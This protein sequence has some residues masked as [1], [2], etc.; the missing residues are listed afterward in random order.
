MLLKCPE[1]NT[2][3]SDAATACPKCGHPMLSTTPA[4]LPDASHSAGWL[5]LAA[6]VFSSFTPAILAP[7]FVLVGLIF[8]GKELKG[9]GK[10]FGTLVL[11]LSLLQG[12]FVL[13]HFGHISGTL[14]LTTAGDAD[15]LAASKYRNASLGLPADW[16]EMVKAKCSEEWPADY[17]M[18]NYC[19]HQQ[20][21]AAQQLSEGAPSDVGAGAFQVIRGKCAGEWPRDFQMRAH[22]ER[23][24]FEGVRSLQ[25]EAVR[26][27]VRNACAQQW[28]DDYKMRRYCES[29]SG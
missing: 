5:S 2:D 10:K 12:W 24:Q 11:C 7:I 17:T 29:K 14:G 4:A 20:Q 16:Q 18:E 25:T 1:C 9:G 26:E 19:N 27:S 6:F 8:A 23:E 21:E 15:A 13:D 28:T 22:C 3:V